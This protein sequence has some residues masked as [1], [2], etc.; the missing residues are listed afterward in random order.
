MLGLEQVEE[1]EDD[2]DERAQLDSLPITI[3]V[4]TVV[5]TFAC[6]A[7]LFIGICIVTVIGRCTTRCR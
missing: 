7:N 5:C 3:A 2:Q 6:R 1:Q 4:S